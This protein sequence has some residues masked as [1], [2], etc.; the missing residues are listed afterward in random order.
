MKKVVTLTE[1]EL[2]NIVK[3]V[4]LENDSFQKKKEKIY[5]HYYIR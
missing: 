1:R 4:I 2:T 3:R 5:I